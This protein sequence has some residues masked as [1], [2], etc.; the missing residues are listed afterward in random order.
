[1]EREQ[2]VHRKK[3]TEG[4]KEVE[5]DVDIANNRKTQRERQ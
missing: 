1:M 4:E 2:K 5:R 3:K